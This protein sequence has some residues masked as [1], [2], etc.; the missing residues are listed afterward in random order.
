MGERKSD[1]FLDFDPEAKCTC[2]HPAMTAILMGRTLIGERVWDISRA[3]DVLESMNEIDSEKIAVMGN[4]G[5]GTTSYYAACMDER[6]KIVM[7]SC[8]ICTYEKSINACVHCTC[9]YIPNIAKYVDMGDLAC[10]IAP[11]PLVMV[12]GQ[13]DKGFNIEGCKKAYATIEAIYEKAG[14]KDKC[15][16][17][18]G[19]E[20]HRFYADL[21]WPVFE[22]LAD[23]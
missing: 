3:I 14:A 2:W 21:A 6:I 13:F 1:A 19:P 23:W 20:G 12:S 11:R 18:I 9:N 22:E 4:S 8:S 10:L 5:G 17:I 16:M 15:R 7:P